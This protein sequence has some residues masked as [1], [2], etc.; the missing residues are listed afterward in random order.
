MS[1]SPLEYVGVD[2]EIVWDA[3]ANKVPVLR[4]QVREILKRE[5]PPGEAPAR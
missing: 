1:P 4:E 5:G 2:Y 3:A